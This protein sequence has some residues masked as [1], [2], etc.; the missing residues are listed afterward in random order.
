[1]TRSLRRRPQRRRR[2]RWTPHSAIV[3]STLAWPLSATAQDGNEALAGLPVLTETQQ[4]VHV[5]NRLG[6]G[7]RPGD[8]ERVR[9]MGI[10]A[11]IESQLHPAGIAD[12]AAEARLAAY[13]FDEMT[14]RELVDFDRSSVPVSARRTETILERAQRMS[15]SPSGGGARQ[16]G[17]EQAVAET[18]RRSILNPA[19]SSMVAL[20]KRRDY[21]I[22]ETRIL[23]AVYSERQ[24]QEVLVDFWVNHFNVNV[25]APY[26]LTEYTD[27]VIRPNVLGKFQDLLVAT[28]T[29]PAMLLYLDNWMSSA[30]EAVVMSRLDAWQPEPGQ[31]RSLELRKR[32]VFFD[33]TS[34]LNEN[35]GRELMELH[36]LGVDGG[37][38]QEDV[39]EVARAFTGWTIAGE[40]QKGGFV[41]DPLLHDVGDKVILGQTIESGAMDE[42]MRVLELLARHPS[43]AHHVSEKLVRRFVA[44]DPPPQLVEAA[45][46]TFLDTGGD[47]R[48]VLRTIF[49]SSEFLSPMYHQ[50]KIKKPHEFVISSLR[51]VNADIDAVDGRAFLYLNRVMRDMGEGFYRHPTPDGYPDVASAWVSTNSLFK[52]LAFSMAVASE[53]IPSTRIYLESAESLFR[54]L[55]FPAA[56]EEQIAQASSL[57]EEARAA[58]A[59][60]TMRDPAMTSSS[61]TMARTGAAATDPTLSAALAAQVV[62]AAIVLGSPDFQ[63]R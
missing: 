21:Q 11:Y 34:G 53:R 44:D 4:I 35:Y 61:M 36:T 56:T 6:Y 40:R 30:P 20:P 29:H 3:L 63:K 2:W 47:I 7:P 23:R 42:G 18:R 48:E 22:L 17:N 52:R 24:L 49:G 43:T 32:K 26:L 33:Q 27:R 45:S 57:L 41:F 19:V 28:A 8:I 55:G 62:A 51:A 38:T 13:R 25:E 31:R 50:A 54:S 46:R 37:Y 12:P 58:S 1:M 60:N 10:G 5:L 16:T 9:A 59:S 14:H 39:I 15:A